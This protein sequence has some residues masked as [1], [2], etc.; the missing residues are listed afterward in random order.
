M[1]YHE[2][3][4]L[5]KP[6]VC[7]SLSPEILPDRTEL[8]ENVHVHGAKI[9]YTEK[10]RADASVCIGPYVFIKLFYWRKESR[11]IFR[12]SVEALR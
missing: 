3:C 2:S 10:T 8:T 7:H 12:I 9:L 5:E 1:R 11:S 4:Y 6:A